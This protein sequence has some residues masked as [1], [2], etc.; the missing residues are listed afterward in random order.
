MTLAAMPAAGQVLDRGSLVTVSEMPFY[1]VLAIAARIQGT[2]IVSAHVS[3]GVIESIKTSPDANEVLASAARKNVSS[4]QFASDVT[5]DVT[6]RF[7][8]ELEKDEGLRPENPEI[9]MRLPELVRIV[10]RPVKPTT[11]GQLGR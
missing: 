11:N 6:V 5:G 7:V 9:L 3:R 10:A 8:Y 4:W 1:P 2:V